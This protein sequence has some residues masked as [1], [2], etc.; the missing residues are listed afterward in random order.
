MF[1][2][3]KIST[4]KNRRELAAK[5]LLLLSVVCLV[6]YAVGEKEKPAKSSSVSVA[7]DRLISEDAP[8]LD[9]NRRSLRMVLDETQNGA[10]AVIR[11]DR[12]DI[13]ASF[14]AGP[15]G[16]PLARTILR[17]ALVLKTTNPG[18]RQAITISVTPTEAELMAFAITNARV[19]VSVCPPGP[20]V[21]GPTSGV[22]FND[23]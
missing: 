3:K 18:G 4:G 8:A 6:L 19:L 23:L 11:G 1:K 15:D 17:N 14:P 16:Q 21:T 2:G 10:G 7:T 20:C 12:I 22:T 13:T 5:A 9:K